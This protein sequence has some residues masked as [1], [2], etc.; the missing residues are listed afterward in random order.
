MDK[1]KLLRH[2]C[3]ASLGYNLY[4]K[5]FDFLKTEVSLKSTTE[6]KRSGLVKIL[7]EEYIGFWAILDQ[8]LFYEDLVSE[9]ETTFSTQ[10]EA[11][12]VQA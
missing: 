4:E 12:T 10:T 1:V 9:L 6:H 3:V 5:S 2:K 8:I 7:G 11:S